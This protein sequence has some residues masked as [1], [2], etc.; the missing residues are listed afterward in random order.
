MIAKVVTVRD[1]KA[2]LTGSGQERYTV[3]LPK[4]TILLVQ[5]DKGTYYI[6]RI[7]G[8]AVRVNVAKTDVAPVN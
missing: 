5:K 1:C 6:T 7:K 2:I 4:G 8:T 3:D